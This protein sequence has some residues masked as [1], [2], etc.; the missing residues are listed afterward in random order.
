MKPMATKRILCPTDFSDASVLALRAGAEHARQASAELLV[1]H[2]ITDA[3]EEIWR[4]KAKEGRD[5][6]GWALW[7]VARD[8]I[9]EKLRRLA[10]QHLGEYPRTRVLASF[11][12]PAEKIAEVVQEEGVELVVLS[13]RRDRTLLQQMLLG[14]VAYRVVRTVPCNVLLVK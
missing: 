13:A 7:K 14:S 5:P 2:V 9:L 1:L 8:E 4:D 10:N 12:D 11:G 3:G 6:S